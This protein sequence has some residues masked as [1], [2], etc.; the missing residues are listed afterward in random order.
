MGSIASSDLHSPKS[1]INLESGVDGGLVQYNTN[2]TN[3][4]QL[5]RNQSERELCSKP[6][7][8][9]TTMGLRMWSIVGGPG[10][11]NVLELR[12]TTKDR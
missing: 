4:N 11:I 8:E 1:S 2:T 6:F 9:I 10:A 3:S 12:G 7:L 5:L